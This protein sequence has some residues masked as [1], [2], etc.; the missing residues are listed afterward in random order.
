MLT[1]RPLAFT[2]KHAEREK[3]KT[4]TTTTMI[5]IIIITEM[6][7]IGWWYNSLTD[8]CLSRIPQR[9]CCCCFFF[10]F[11]F[12]RS[13]FFFLFSSFMYVSTQAAIKR[14]LPASVQYLCFCLSRHT[15][16][17]HLSLSY[18]RSIL[19]FTLVWTIH[20]C[21][22]RTILLLFFIY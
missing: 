4:T 10:L 15:F 16:Q 12:F 8:C 20:R 1:V 19:S 3:M 22:K 11:L 9:R 18:H 5:T 14:I 13:F 17:Q 7:K 6:T 2:L 21:R